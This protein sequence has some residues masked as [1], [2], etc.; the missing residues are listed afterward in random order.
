MGNH[1]GGTRQEKSTAVRRKK[2]G[3]HSCEGGGRSVRNRRDIIFEGFMTGARPI[4][5][6]STRGGGL[7]CAGGMVGYFVGTKKEKFEEISHPSFITL[8]KRETLK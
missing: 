8:G 6:A 1:H 3:A 5:Q 7:S 4:H 2:R